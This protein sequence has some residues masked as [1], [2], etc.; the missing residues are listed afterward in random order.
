MI[1]YCLETIECNPDLEIISSL[2]ET[3]ILYLL[4]TVSFINQTNEHPLEFFLKKTKNIN[5]IH[6]K[7]QRIAL[8]EAI[9]LKE[10]K[11]IDILLHQ[12]SCDINLATSEGQ[13]LL[14]NFNSYHL[15]VIYYH[16]QNMIYLSMMNNIIKLYIIISRLLNDR[17]NIYKYFIYLL[18]N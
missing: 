15:F 8:L 9:H 6:H 11:T 12:S 17:M 7:T 1:R 16:I 18:K 3:N 10:T 14:V 2:E 13:Y 5:V 4:R